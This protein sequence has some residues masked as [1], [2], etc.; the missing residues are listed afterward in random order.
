LEHCR[1]RFLFHQNGPKGE[2]DPPRFA[3]SR[4][5]LTRDLD[6]LH[7]G[8]LD[9]LLGHGDSEHAVLHG[10]PDLLRLSVL[11]EPEPAHELAAAA[12]HAVPGVRLL[13]L[14]LVALAADLEDV[15]VL[16]L[17]LHLLLLQPGDVRL[18]H[19]RLRSLLPVHARAGEGRDLGAGARERGEEAAAAAAGAEREALKGIPDVEGEGVE[20]VAAA[21]QRHGRWF[22]GIEWCARNEGLGVLSWLLDDS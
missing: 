14:L 3:P 2:L 12:L 4:R 8:L 6:G 5:R 7:L 18:E 1:T 11:G 10:G 22:G 15:A 16:D 17:N 13:L 21:D 9:L 20:H 19:V